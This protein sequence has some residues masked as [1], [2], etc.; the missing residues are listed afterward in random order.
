M[1][2]K[3]I[4]H[5]K[6]LDFVK[7]HGLATVAIVVLTA[8]GVY[9]GAKYN[10]APSMGHAYLGAN[11]YVFYGTAAIGIIS[12]MGICLG[13]SFIQSGR[14]LPYI[15]WFG[16]NS[17]RVMALHN[18]IKGIV[19]IVVAK[20]FSITTGTINSNASYATITLVFT[21]LV[22]TVAVWLISWLLQK[23]LGRNSLLK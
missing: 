22:T 19:M 10:G 20:L 15:K 21:I 17:F 13:L 8:T 14:I 23:A 1:L 16:K 9:F 4:G 18:P 12:F 2:L 5:D 3:H 7:K 11:P 6:I